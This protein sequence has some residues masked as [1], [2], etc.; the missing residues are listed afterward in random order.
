MRWRGIVN[1]YKH[2]N[3]I[4]L[5]KNSHLLSPHTHINTDTQK[6][7]QKHTPASVAGFMAANKRNVG[8]LGNG[9]MSPRSERTILPDGPS[10]SPARRSRACVCWIV[11]EMVCGCECV[12]VCVCG[13]SGGVYGCAGAVIILMPMVHITCTY[14]TH[15]PTQNTHTHK[16]TPKLT[17]NKTTPPH[18]TKPTPLSRKPT[19]TPLQVQ[20]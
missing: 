12:I 11:W 3:T 10:R 18:T 13:N 19:H 14:H 16:P 5:G 6:H 2:R 8:C 20:G 9:C 7:T 17:H 15:K 1:M 4:H